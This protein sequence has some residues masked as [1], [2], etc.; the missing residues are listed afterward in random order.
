[1]S[2]PPVAGVRPKHAR[3]VLLGLLLSVFL[4][5][6]D[7]QVVATA[8]PRI[9]TDLGGSGFAWITTGY[10]LASTISAPAYGKFGDQ[11]GRKPVFVTAI[12]LFLAGSVACAIAPTL[13][14]LIAS[15][16]LQGIGAGGLFVSVVSILFDLYPGRER[17]RVMGYFSVCFAIASLAGP[18]VGGLLT[19]LLGW[20]SI[21]LVTVLAGALALAV[22]VKYLRLPKPRGRAVLDWRGLVLLSGAIG[23][24]TLLTSWAGSR[25]PWLSWPIG[26]LAIVAIACGAAFVAAERRAR[27][28]VLPLGL[29]RDGTFRV[30]TS[31]SVIAGFVFLGTVNYLALFVQAIGVT[32]ASVTGLVLSPMMLGVVASSMLSS[33][34]IA[35]TG[36]YHRYPA[37]SMALGVVSCALLS[38]MDASVPLPLVAGTLTVFGLAA[39]LNMQVLGLAAQNTA[40]PPDIGAVSGAITFLRSLGT[41]V[42]ISVFGSVF[43]ATP[44]H[45]TALH[46]V[47]LT[48]GALLVLGLVVSLSLKNIPLS[49]KDHS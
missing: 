35:K 5:M 36:S 23:A 17:A 25:Y 18:A 41:A 10:L 45:V 9:L 3:P 29:F 37:A 11:F 47:A 26:A 6:L 39:G 43:T 16:V 8:L 34:R 28:P 46:H 49:T 44:D 32:S 22:V 2:S 48:A 1:M 33:R 7:A 4:A 15:R 13:P 21:F 38:T 31:V 30:A 20:R 40:P 19:D 27:E 24:L 42:G 12:A 14:L